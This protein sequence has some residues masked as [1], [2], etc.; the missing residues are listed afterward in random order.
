MSNFSEGPNIQ[1]NSTGC[2]DNSTGCHLGSHVHVYDLAAWKL[3]CSPHW[4][5]LQGLL[6]LLGSLLGVPGN[7]LALKYFAR[8]SRSSLSTRLYIAICTV[9]LVT[10]FAHLP[11]MVSLLQDR[12]PLLFSSL[13]FLY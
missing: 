8:V 4:D 5:Q 9:D 10:C 13:A 12:R 3:A 6:L 7:A 2:H 11:V 1:F